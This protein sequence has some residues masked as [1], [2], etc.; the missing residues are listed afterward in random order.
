M[1]KRLFKGKRKDN[2][3]WVYWNV[4]GT[5]VDPISM[6]SCHI[7]IV[8]NAGTPKEWVQAMVSRIS[9]VDVDENTICEYTGKTDKNGTKIFEGDFIKLDDEVKKIFNVDDGVVRYA[10]GGFYVGKFCSLS[11]L[12]TLC[13]YDGILRGEIIG[14]KFDNDLEVQDD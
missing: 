10:W 8:H 14:N 9:L 7:R 4:L 12:M 6:N 11:S 5:I 13:S 1:R 2:G 3:E